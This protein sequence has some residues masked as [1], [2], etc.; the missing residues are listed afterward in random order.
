MKEL[1]GADAE[2]LLDMLDLIVNSV[3][4]HVSGDDSTDVDPSLW[5]D[6]YKAMDLL[7]EH[8]RREP[9]RVRWIPKN[10]S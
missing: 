3:D 1:D 8:G 5:D 10:A 7:I 4:E 6:Y 2:E 9:R